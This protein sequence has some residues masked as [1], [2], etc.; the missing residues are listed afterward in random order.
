AGNGRAVTASNGHGSQSRGNGAGNGRAGDGPAEP[1]AGTF[2]I[3]SGEEELLH[4]M[5]NGWSLAK[6]LA[7]GRYLIRRDDTG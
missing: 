4:H 2:N 7:N 3:V 1:G 5:N 6:E